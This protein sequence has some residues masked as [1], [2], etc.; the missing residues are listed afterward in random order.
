MR[1]PPFVGREFVAV[2][3]VFLAGFAGV[4]L[5]AA[6]G[7]G[8]ARLGQF[9]NHKA[10][11]WRT[12]TNRNFSFYFEAGSAAEPRVAEIEASAEAA[13]ASVL[14]LMGEADFPDRIHVFL[15]DSK[16][17]MKELMGGTGYGGAI[18]RLRVVFAIVNSTNNGCSTHEF[19]HV[20]AGAT[21]GKPERW[22]DEGFATYADER[23]RQRETIVGRL[24]A[25]GRLL[26]I[27]VLAEDFLKHPETVTYLESASLL[28][29]VIERY[30]W[31]KFK[32]IWRGGLR[33]LP[34]VLGRDLETLEAEWRA[35]L[36]VPAAPDAAP[37]SR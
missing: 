32:A 21:W 17:R 7:F 28:G 23:W 15:V 4:R 13:R 14:R 16:P 8:G 3:V 20:I 29:F 25:Q 22:I 31:D 18:A 19:C 30:H 6:P 33:S 2:L 37:A 34:R 27:R 1:C 12:A 9:T 10:F 26:P 35:T 11:H 24:G 5:A 36:P